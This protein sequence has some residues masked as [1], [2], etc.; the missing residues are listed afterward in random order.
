V[1]GASEVSHGPRIS[2]G[3]QYSTNWAG[4]AVPTSIGG[5]TDVIG[6]WVVPTIQ[7][8]NGKNYSSAWVGIDGDN[9]NSVEQIGTEQDY[10][11]GLRSYFAWYEMYPQY[12]V[13]LDKNRYPVYSG[14]TITAEVKYNAPNTPLNS[15]TLT[16]VDVT[17]N[18][19]Y[20]AP[21]QSYNPASRSSAEWIIE[22]PWMG[23]VLPLANFGTINFRNAKATIN[24]IIDT[25]DNF[26]SDKIIMTTK[27]GVVKAVPSAFTGPGAFSVD[28]QHK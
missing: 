8:S 12:P 21:P 16:L 28:W 26:N 10:I 7:P 23:T 22:A 9:S 25:V 17:G 14:D 2:E 11:N 13:N 3:T 5:V 1:H 6:T 15:F 27:G 20:T 18:W 24:G 19:S 4:Y